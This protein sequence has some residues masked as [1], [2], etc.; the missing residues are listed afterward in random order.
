MPEA[1]CKPST[2]EASDRCPGSL[3]LHE[4]EDGLLA[5][6]R[7]P[8]GRLRA[9]Q[10]EALARAAGL[11]NGLVELTSRANVQ[12][13]G[14]RWGVR[15]D[16]AALLERAGLL[17]SV[18]HDRARNVI[19]SPVAGR[20]PRA[21]AMTDGVVA[22]IDRGLC[23]D[24]ALSGLPG[25]FL[26]AV[27]DGSGFGLDPRAHVTLVARSGEAFAVAAAGCRTSVR[28]GAHAAAHAAIRAAAAFLA[29]R[30]GSE[31]RAWPVAELPG[32]VC[33]IGP[34]RLVQRD[35]R[36]ALTGLAPLGR[37][38]RDQLVTLARIADRYGGELRLSTER[39]VTLVDVVAGRANEA[40]T[41]LA[42]L[43][44]VLS[45]DSGWVGLTACAGL[46]RCSKALV[47][48]R[49]AAARRAALR[50]PGAAAEHWAACA[51]RCGERADQP[52]AATAVPEGIL[53]RRGT[54]ELLASGVDQA[55][56]ALA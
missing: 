49:A 12:V 34:G 56:E 40:E 10:L 42:G 14:L 9:A 48:V 20:H 18:M 52:L 41:A 36:V 23:A 50:A 25:R 47:D 4:A 19:A 7:V 21:L 22:A 43:G 55:L 37:L 8:G 30:R 2:R 24:P 27:D 5:R 44:L 31:A 53:V 51:R 45:P 54:D 17:P 28:V 38:E 33:R 29:A 46:G 13:R 32:D 3:L 11:G 6:I 1:L 16:L 26:F 35:G 15:D 39:T